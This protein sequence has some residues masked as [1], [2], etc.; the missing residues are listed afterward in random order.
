MIKSIATSSPY[1]SVINGYTGIPSMSPGAQSAGML[2]W[3]TSSNCVEVYNGMSWHTVETSVNLDFTERADRAIK[4]AESK[5]QEE[6]KLQA[7]MD[8]HPGLREAHDKYEMLKVLV[9]QQEINGV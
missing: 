1:L 4:W 2:R 3:N 6:S 9:A 5:M 7:L 8:R